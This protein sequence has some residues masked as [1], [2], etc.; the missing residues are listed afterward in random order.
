MRYV[1][2]IVFCLA[3]CLFVAPAAAATILFSDVARDA[4]AV[5]ALGVHITP[6]GPNDI[7]FVQTDWEVHGATPPF[8]N[9]STPSRYSS[10]VATF[11]QPITRLTL[12]VA[13]ANNSGWQNPITVTAFDQ[14]KEVTSTNV[15]LM[16]LGDWTQITI[17]GPAIDQVDWSG[18]GWVFH[19]YFVRDLSVTFANDVTSPKVGG[20]PGVGSPVPEPASLGLVLLTCVGAVMRRRRVQGSR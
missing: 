2:L 18:N 17:S 14:G 6:T 8:L 20:S 10:G 4:G 16:P 1:G 5:S 13:R 9:N 7:P 15:N 3:S 19:P 11:D 12:D